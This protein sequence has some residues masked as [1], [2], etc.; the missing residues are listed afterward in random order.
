MQRIQLGSHGHVSSPT[1]FWRSNCWMQTRPGRR[2]APEESR[3][4]TITKPKRDCGLGQHRVQADAGQED[5]VA[6]SMTVRDSAQ[7]RSVARSSCGQAAFVMGVGASEDYRTP[8][9]RSRLYETS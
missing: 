7:C 6:A 4:S 2:G 3:C 9:E 1:L 5:M 8:P